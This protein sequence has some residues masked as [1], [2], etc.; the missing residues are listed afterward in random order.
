MALGPVHVVCQGTSTPA[1]SQGP[2]I[3]ESQ[4]VAPEPLVATRLSLVLQWRRTVREQSRMLTFLDLA[5][6]T[7]GVRLA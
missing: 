5:L 3:A 1:F 2:D 4:A 7:Q 6:C